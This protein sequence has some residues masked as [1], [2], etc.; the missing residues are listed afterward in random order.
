[1]RR[2]R[3]EPVDIAGFAMQKWPTNATNATF[4][5]AILDEACLRSAKLDDAKFR[6]TSLKNTDMEDA[7]LQR[8][9]FSGSGCASLKLDGA[10]TRDA[11]GL[12]EP[13][14]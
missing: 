13:T 3:L 14:E 5:E 7:T 1:M 11:E 9:D 6:K 8:A 2:A 10:D 4:D 12:P